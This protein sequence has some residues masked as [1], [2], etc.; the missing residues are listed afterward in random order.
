[1]TAL[2]LLDNPVRDRLGIAQAMRMMW[3]AFLDHHG[4]PAAQL[5]IDVLDDQ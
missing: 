3:D 4:D 1:M 5:V 2:D